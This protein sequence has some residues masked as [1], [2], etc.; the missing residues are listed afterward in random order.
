MQE[1][2]D[3][4]EKSLIRQK[5]YQTENF[6]L[7]PEMLTLI[8][9]DIYDKK[10]TGWMTKGSL[11]KIVNAMK[12]QHPNNRLIGKL[13]HLGYLER[14]PQNPDNRSKLTQAACLLIKGPA[15]EIITKQVISEE[16][17]KVLSLFESLKTA[18]VEYLSLQESQA[19]IDNELSKLQENSLYLEKKL[20]KL[21]QIILKRAEENEIEIGKKKL[22]LEEVSAKITPRLIEA[23]RRFEMLNSDLPQ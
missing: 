1:E 6:L 20:E 12:L 21:T 9:S 7:T 2:I 14:D 18:S 15:A 17:V 5:Q 10:G 13:F 23:H 16:E 22:A 19:R 4:V 8:I 11:F 3:L